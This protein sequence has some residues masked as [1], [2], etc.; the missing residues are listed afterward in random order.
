MKHV[1]TGQRMYRLAEKTTGQFADVLIEHS[2]LSSSS[3]DSLTVLDNACGT[4]I[5]TAK[6]M[7][8]EALSPPTRD[9]IDLTSA[10]FADAMLEATENMAKSKGWPIK[11][12]KADA[13]DTKL[14]SDQFSHILFSFGPMLMKDP[15]AS[16]RECM[17]MLRPGGVLGTNTWMHVPWIQEYRPAFGNH[18]ELPAYPKTDLEIYSI[19]SE[20]RQEWHK[21]EQVKAYYESAGFEAVNVEAVT[22]TSTYEVDDVITML[23]HTMGMFAAK[24][25][26]SDE[27]QTK[28][29]PTLKV[30][31]DYIRRTYPEGRLTWTWVAAVATGR[32]PQ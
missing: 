26:S 14:P 9:R 25:W 1:L 27:R 32:K 3:L 23:P 2:G 22:R 29:A 4:G 8:G 28:L 11:T 21:P 17:R 5:V 30:L 7:E 19:F 15:M 24:L 20:S 18:P 16:I 31:E 13:M 12:V 10:D 6:L